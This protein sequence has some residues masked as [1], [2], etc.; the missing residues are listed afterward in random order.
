MDPINIC[1][2]VATGKS[3]VVEY[4]KG[5]PGAL[6][7]PGTEGPINRFPGGFHYLWRQAAEHGVLSEEDVRRARGLFTGTLPMDED[8]LWKQYPRDTRLW[9]NT[10]FRDLQ[11]MCHGRL[12]PAVE[13]I[14][15]ELGQ[16]SRAE[17]AGRA[18]LLLSLLS[19]LRLAYQ[20]IEKVAL[21]ETSSRFTLWN[22]LFHPFDFHQRSLF[23][24]MNTVVVER[25]ILDQFADAE[26]DPDY[27]NDPNPARKF[28]F[29]HQRFRSQFLA[30]GGYGPED[31]GKIWDK[32]FLWREM[33]NG[34]LIYLSFESFVLR[35]EV[36]AE[37][38]A[39]LGIDAG[40]VEQRVASKQGTLFNPAVSAG[41]IGKYRQ[42]SDLEARL[43]EIEAALPAYVRR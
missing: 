26:K 22:N 34:K 38:C 37:I 40:A 20:R 32:G 11:K 1:G 17:P 3:A 25:D 36:R 5:V 42:R 21:A 18:Q 30:R 43:R 41:N 7:W 14:L 24:R 13:R 19:A 6:L 28:C 35:P 9:L 15:A 27:I 29:V 12:E 2:F 8:P 4:F 10:G 23:G 39:L 31:V 16:L 33:E